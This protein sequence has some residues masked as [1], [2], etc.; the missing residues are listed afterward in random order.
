MALGYPG[1]CATIS[2]KINPGTGLPNNVFMDNNQLV[3]PT[4]GR[5]VHY[6]PNEGDNHCQANGAVVL[7]ATVVQAFGPSLNLAVTCMNPDG[8]MVLRY[9]VPHKTTAV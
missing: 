3:L 6:F 1:R 9:S 8:P 4:T 5:Q 7:P 2:N